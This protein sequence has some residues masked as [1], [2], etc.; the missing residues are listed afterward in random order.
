LECRQPGSPDHQGIVQLLHEIEVAIA[1]I[2][3]EQAKHEEY[4]KLEDLEKRIM[5]LEV[6]SVRMDVSLILHD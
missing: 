4:Q 2:Q 6:G 3:N 1:N 5:G